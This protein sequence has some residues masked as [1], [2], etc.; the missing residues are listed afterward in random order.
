MNSRPLDLLRNTHNVDSLREP[1]RRATGPLTT[2]QGLG[3]DARVRLPFWHLS[4]S[5][6]DHLLLA[7]TISAYG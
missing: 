1:D 2:V 6:H 3:G 7:G 4:R 5:V